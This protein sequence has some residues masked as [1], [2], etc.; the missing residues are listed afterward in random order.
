MYKK[1]GGIRVCGYRSYSV[2]DLCAI[3]IAHNMRAKTLRDWIDKH[4]LECFYDGR[5]IMIY[6][7]VFNEFMDKRDEAQKRTLA[8]KEFRCGKCKIISEP[9]NN[10]V[11]RLISSDIGS[12]IA[13]GICSCGHHFKKEYKKKLY[14]EIISS[15]NVLLDE[16]GRLSDTLPS[17]SKSTLKDDSKTE[18]SYSLLISS[19]NTSTSTNKKHF[20]Q[21]YNFMDML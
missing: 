5:K 7:A 1:Y 8:F 15:F 2:A 13:Y 20:Q 3:Y 16:A 11:T 4:G 12:L 10:E 18:L 19:E 21:Q 9:V 6:G 14:P 17:T